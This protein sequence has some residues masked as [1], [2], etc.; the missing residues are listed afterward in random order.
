MI[1][2]AL[3]DV[4]ALM[5]CKQAVKAGTRLTPDEI[6][7]LLEESEHATDPRFCPHGRPTSVVIDREGLERWF[8]RK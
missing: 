1:G 3:R 6:R 5:A 4:A 2:K 7:T 8:D